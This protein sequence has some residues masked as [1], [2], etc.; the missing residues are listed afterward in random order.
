MAQRRAR[1]GRPAK[2]G[3][4]EDILEAALA[5][6]SATG[7]AATRLDD[8]AERA[9]I[10]KAT[11]YLY[12]KNKEDLFEGVVRRWIVPPVRQIEDLAG[13]DDV[14]AEDLIRAQ[15]RTFYRDLVGTRLRLIMRLMV[16]EGERFPHLVDFY[17]TNVIQRGL[18]ALSRAIQRGIDRGEFRPTAA[19]DLPQAIAGPA[20]LA[21]LWKLLFDAHKPLDLDALCEA[22]L[23]VVMRGLR[24]AGVKAP[25]CRPETRRRHD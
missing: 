20:I 21:A 4:T 8:V 5:A 10:S 11:I 2:E 13:R 19:V 17:Y 12:F 9:G 22:H 16:A 6:F 1:R 23:D 14:S 25:S 24:R 7:F 15:I 18:A 3:R